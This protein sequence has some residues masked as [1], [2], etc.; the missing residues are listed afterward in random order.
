MGRK[1]NMTDIATDEEVPLATDAEVG[2]LLI[3]HAATSKKDGCQACFDEWPCKTAKLLARLAK[4]EGENRKL[5][6]GV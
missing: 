1:D 3:A 5:K 6:G 2:L 4:V